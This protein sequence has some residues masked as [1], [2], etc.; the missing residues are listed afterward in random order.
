MS[1]DSHANPALHPA[2]AG[3]KVLELARILA[4]PWAGQLLA[5]LGADVVKVERPGS[6]DDTRHWGPPFVPAAAP[7]TVP[8]GHLGAAYF[9]STNRGK[10]SIAVDFE[11]SEG[12]ETVLNL[13]AHA[14]VLIENFKVG[15]LKK[16]GLDHATMR[17]RFPRLIYCSITGFGQ[18]GPY[19]PRAGYDFLAQGM[20]GGMSL[21]GEPDAP[22]L[23]TGYAVADIGSGLY[24]TTAI[25]A[26]LHRRERTGEGA[27]IDCSLLDTQVAL[28]GYQVLN[29]A[30]GGREP[31]RY[32]N[33][34]PNIVPYDVFPVADGHI[35]IAAANDGQFRKLVAILGA[36]DLAEDPR[37]LEMKDRAAHRIVLTQ[38]LHA[39]TC[40]FRRDDLLPLLDAAAV[41]AGPINTVPQ[42]LADPQIKARNVMTRVPQ[43]AARAGM[44]D[45]V[46]PAFLI[47]GQPAIAARASPY[48]GQHTQD[49]LDDPAWGGPLSLQDKA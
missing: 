14:D 19:A 3:L 34:H 7:E 1:T 35:I 36:P 4:G 38:L 9:H 33:A 37:F 25:L 27:F 42:V 8:H 29:Y 23:K 49:V 41:P 15:G 5:D 40:R 28:L 21:T 20:G 45:T 43:E 11:T 24:A 12:R 46:R 30:I 48:L 10:R 39:L 44:V 18:T 31:Q 13:I 16:Y 47:D 6:G 32:G 26:A 17:S 2:L 22:P